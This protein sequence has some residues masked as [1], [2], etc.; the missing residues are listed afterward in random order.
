MRSRATRTRLLA[1]R[2]GDL[3]TAGSGGVQKVLLDPHPLAR[4]YD[5]DPGPLGEQG[6]IFR[7]NAQD[8]AK[9]CRVGAEIA[10]EAQVPW[11]KCGAQV[12]TETRI[13]RCRRGVFQECH[14][15]GERY[16]G[17]LAAEHSRVKPGAGE[18]SLRRQPLR[19]Q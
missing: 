15:S 13:T 16:A 12:Q 4:R 19:A 6:Q 7:R 3:P 10:D 18:D 1:P 8:V 9:G 5:L 2:A 11:V 17:A 14:V